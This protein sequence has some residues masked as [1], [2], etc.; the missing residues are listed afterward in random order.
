MFNKSGATRL[1]DVLVSKGIISSEQL[2]HAI[3]EQ[4]SRRKTLDPDNLIAQQAT[5]LG[6]ILIELGYIDR[7]QLKRGLNWQL[8]LRKVTMAMALCAPLLSFS[9]GA[10][11]AIAKTVVPIPAK[12]EAENYTTQSGVV[13]ETSTDVG[14][15]KDVGNINASDWLDYSN[16]AVSVP[17]TGTYIISY[18]VASLRGGASFTLNEVAGTTS[19]VIDT[20]SVPQTGGWQTWVT[21]QRTVSLKAGLHYFNITALA[22]GANINWFS[23]E[24]AAPTSSAASSSVVSSVASSAAPTSSAAATT[25]SSKSS[26]ASSAPVSSAAAVSSAVS[27]P[28]AVS[29]SKSSVASSAAPVSSSSSSVASSATGTAAIFQPVTIQAEN[30]ATM[31]GVWNESTTDVGG[32]QDTGNIDAGDWMSYT[33]TSITIPVTGTYKITYRVASYTAGGSFNLTEAGTGA[34]LNTVTVPV[35]GGWQTWV[36]VVTTVQ[37]TAGVHNFG[38]NA[39][40]GGFNVNWF[41]IEGTSGTA[42]SSS[43]ATTVKPFSTTIEAENYATMS[44]VWNEST[45]DVGGGQDTGNIDTGD[46]MLYTNLSV[47]LPATGTY[48]VTYRV[49]SLPGGGSLNLIEAGVGTVFDTAPIPKTGGYQ[50]WIDVKRTVTLTAGLHNFGIVAAVGGFNVNWFR[51]EST[52]TTTSSSSTSTTTSSSS[53]SSAPS[54]TSSSLSSSSKSSAASSASSTS[55]SGVVSTVVAGAVGMNWV[56]PSQRLDGTVLDITEVGG[57]EVRYKLVSAADFTY[58]SINDAYTTQY[59]FPW[60][61]GNYVFQVAAFDKNGVYSSFVDVK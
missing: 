59:N 3:K 58:I 41:R 11:A 10:A 34:I 54:V 30:Y 13:V 46:W 35:T 44:G 60:L 36:D 7:L 48:T 32:G 23:V 29:S 15:G 33:N 5:S 12:I 56:P 61:E 25:S 51:I 26:V 47:N 45:T 4:T 22:A 20:V 43:S 1:G 57:Y 19:T 38:I 55:S 49:A 40:V 31:S 18:R 2:K 52:G 16:T 21:V 8:V 37:L 53:S 17:T 14:A 42:S 39:V 6:E 9:T 50:T 24:A 28:A 27:S